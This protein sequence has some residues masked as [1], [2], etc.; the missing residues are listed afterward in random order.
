MENLSKEALLLIAIELNLPGLLQFWSTNSRRNDLI[1]KRNDICNSK[2]KNKFPNYVSSLKQ[3]TS[4]ETYILLY[5]LT[6]LKNKLNFN[7]S[8][9]HLYN[10]RE[11]IYKNYTYIKMR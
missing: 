4:R 5:K 2:W 10:G 3:S 6:I 9:E 7:G 8:I 1:S 11:L